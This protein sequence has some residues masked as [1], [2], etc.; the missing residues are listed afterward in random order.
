M[1]LMPLVYVTD[2]GRA[3]DFYTKLLPASNVVTTSPH[4]T[5]LNVGGA[6]LALHLAESVDHDGD[7]MA[8]SLD[9]AVTLEQLIS[10][11]S[12]AGIEPSGEICDQPFGRSVTVTDPDG[13][14][15][16]ISEH[17]KPAIAT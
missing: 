16:Q 5:E 17:S 15:I 2:M 14:V 13:L 7:G 6:S 12:E 10:L 11:L 9:A 1:K 8:L 4:W 3:I